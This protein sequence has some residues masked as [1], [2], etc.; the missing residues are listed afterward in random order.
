MDRY[1]IFDQLTELTKLTKTKEGYSKFIQRGNI[2][3]YDYNHGYLDVDVYAYQNHKDKKWFVR[4]WFATIDD[5]DY[6]GWRE[7][8]TKLEANEV[9]E[10]IATN[11]FKDMV[12]LP[13]IEELNKLLRKYGIAV[14]YE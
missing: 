8:A 4:I 1:K 11:V 5:G 14:G 6:G 2:E 9:V 7:V 3:F 12:S 10:K 13:T